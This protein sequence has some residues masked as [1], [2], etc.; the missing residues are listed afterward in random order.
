MLSL[1]NATPRSALRSLHSC[2]LHLD[3]KAVGM[4][5]W[6]ERFRAIGSVWRDT[7][8][9]STFSS[10]SLTAEMS[11]ACC[12]SSSLAAC[13]DFSREAACCR[14]ALA[15]ACLL[16]ASIAFCLFL[17]SSCLCLANSSSAR[18]LASSCCLAPLV[19]PK[20]SACVGR[21]RRSGSCS[22]RCCSARG[23]RDSVPAPRMSRSAKYDRRTR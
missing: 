23:V 12:T 7:R 21:P 1:Q 15:A 11:P 5:S 10:H 22:L 8:R 16:A 20:K 18:V 14:A 13:R 3:S 9:V 2:L 17:P 6:W 19:P 4:G